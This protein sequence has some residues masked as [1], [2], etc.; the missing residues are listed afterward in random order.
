MKIIHID[1]GPDGQADAHIIG[2]PS[3]SAVA[4]YWAI[5]TL[6]IALLLEAFWPLP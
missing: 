5:L 2:H 1:A 4:C 3:W 6:L